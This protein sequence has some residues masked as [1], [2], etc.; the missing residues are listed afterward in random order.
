MIAFRRQMHS[1]RL[2]RES[3]KARVF[4]QDDLDAA[5]AELLLNFGDIGA[6]LLAGALATIIAAWLQDHHPCARGNQPIETAQHAGR[7]VAIDTRIDDANVMAMRAQQRFELSGVSLAPGNALAV[8]VAG[9]E[10]HDGPGRCIGRCG[11]E[12]RGD[13]GDQ[14]CDAGAANADAPMIEMQGIVL[15][16][17]RPAPRPPFNPAIAPSAQ[18]HPRRGRSAA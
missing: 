15:W 9:A 11:R 8:G 10:R 16:L 17:F 12:E 1:V 5:S 14:D 6:T 13:Q 2:V 4:K 18:P 3:A 7:G